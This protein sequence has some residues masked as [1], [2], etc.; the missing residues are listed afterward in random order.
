LSG[1]VLEQETGTVLGGFA[2]VES[3]AFSFRLGLRILS[4]TMLALG[5]AVAPL[6]WRAAMGLG[7]PPGASYT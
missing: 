1:P 5:L 7:A 2:K 6:L 4:L 3:I